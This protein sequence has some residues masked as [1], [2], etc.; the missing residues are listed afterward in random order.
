MRKLLQ[1]RLEYYGP[2]V[3]SIFLFIEV[4]NG[5]HFTGPVQRHTESML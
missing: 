4:S 5:F 1:L 3:L 2:N